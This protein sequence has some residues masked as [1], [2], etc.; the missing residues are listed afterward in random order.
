MPKA[1]PSKRSTSTKSSRRIFMRK[2]N[3]PA[4]L[5]LL[6]CWPGPSSGQQL[7]YADLILRGGK[8]ITVDGQDRI[9]EAVAVAG[10]RI[11]AIGSNQQISRL[12]GPQTR[13][14]E[15]NGRALL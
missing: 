9:M 10:N 15:L 1:N 13:I 4:A 11:M 2:W 8:V 6:A 5:L 3:L 12:A 7:Q 14:I